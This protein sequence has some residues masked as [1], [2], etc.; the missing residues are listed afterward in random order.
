MGVLLRMQR[1]GGACRVLAGV[2]LGAVG[3]VGQ[4]G[5]EMPPRF[6]EESSEVDA[7]LLRSAYPSACVGLE[8]Q[9]ADVREHTA[10]RLAEYEHVRVANECLC[11]GLYDAE[12]GAIGE[13]ALRG[14]ASSRRDDLAEC[15]LPAL[16]DSR[17]TGEGRVSVVRGLGGMEARAAYGAL[18]ELVKTDPEPVIRAE[19][20]KALNPSAKAVKVL[21]AAL[22][23]DDAASVRT[24]AAMGLAGRKN[25]DAE[26]ALRTA[27]AKDPD[28]STRAAAAAALGERPSA[29]N[30]GAMCTALMNDDDEGV[31][32]SVVRAWEGTRRKR[33]LDCLDDRMGKLEESGPV[34][35]AI[36][37]TLVSS[38]SK[39]AADMLCNNMSSWVRMYIRDKVYLEVPGSDIVKAQNDRDYERS[40]ECVRKAL[41][42]GGYSCYGKNYL[43]HWMREFGGSASTPL[44][45]GMERN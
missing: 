26:A 17:V 40:F 10:R 7:F 27:L 13:S 6:V 41:R 24:A 23:T 11:K 43:G 45:P 4:V 20:A 14:V 21:V 3:L 33:V 35:S 2:A 18:A 37:E 5:C 34:R 19:A 8:A 39:Q 22:A 12:T 15:V 16:S 44:C 31:R 1:F 28:G 25:A 36:L 30:T 32:A 42:K 9:N 38:S 29:E